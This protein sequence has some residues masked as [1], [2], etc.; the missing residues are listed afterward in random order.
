M[1][2]IQEIIEKRWSPRAFAD[3]MPERGLL[4]ELLQKAGTAPSCFNEQ[5]WRY[6]I[7]FKGEEG[8]DKILNCL[9]EGNQQWAKTSP[10]L[11][12]AFTKDY[13]DHNGKPNQ[14]ARHD[15][16]AVAAYFT[17]LAT[18]ENL[19]VHQM[20]GIDKEAIQSNYNPPE[21][22]SPHTAIAIGYLGD[23]A[24]L[25]EKLREKESAKKVRQPLSDWVFMETFGK[26]WEG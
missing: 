7:G 26:P 13:F 24:I 16:G 2:D 23:A 5:P 8:Y 11:I 3:K 6:I 1:M 22:I 25:P 9:K 4:K 12:L 14:H 18:A 21:G 15:L 19:Y 20:A 10:V 17:L